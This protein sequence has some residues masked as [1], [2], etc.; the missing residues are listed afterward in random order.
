MTVITMP[1]HVGKSHHCLSLE[2][3]S[4]LYFP[5]FPL[6]GWSAYVFGSQGVREAALLWP[7]YLLTVG[8]PHLIMVL[9]LLSLYYLILFPNS[10]SVMETSG[11]AAIR[12]T[13]WSNSGPQTRTFNN[14]QLHIKTD[15]CEEIFI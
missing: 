8:E 15:S 11:F 10:A 7:A 2:L 3:Q 4:R 5:T 14:K 13:V 9:Q 1:L 12:F 6:I